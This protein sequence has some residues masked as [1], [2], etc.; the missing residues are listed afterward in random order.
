M[1]DSLGHKS[2]VQ[3]GTEST[4]GTAVA[5]TARTEL[6]SCGLKPVI[7]TIEDPSLYSSPSLRSIF[8]GPI[9]F[10]GPLVFRLNFEG[11]L[12]FFEGAFGTG[13]VTVVETSAR[14]ITFKEAST[15][16][17][18]TIEVSKGDLPTGKVERYFG[19][20]MLGVKVSGKAE[21]GPGTMLRAEFD[22]HAKDMTTNFTKTAALSFPGIFPVLNWQAITVDDGTADSAADVRV[23]E[24]EVE[25]TNNMNVER[26]FTGS[27]TPDQPLRDNFLQ[28]KWRITKKYKTIVLADAA[29]AFTTGSPKLVFRNAA[30]GIGGSSFR[31]FELRS[32][33]AQITDYESSVDGYGEVEQT[34]EWTA[35][36]DAT[37]ASALVARFRSLETAI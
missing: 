26:L 3:I 29:R 32:N 6:I 4:Y 28:V 30:V 15:L 5:A 8:Q 23:T 27:Q 9:Y 25:L 33:Q 34:V 37:D 36:F 35:F 18:Y 16:K 14:D 7:S 24:W 17:S 20:T 19:S 31:E 1:A 11:L 10:R 21:A 22:V 12:K 13:A 2:D